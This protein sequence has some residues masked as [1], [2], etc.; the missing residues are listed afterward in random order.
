MSDNDGVPVV[1]KPLYEL[2]IGNTFTAI[3]LHFYQA[4]MDFWKH[5]HQD[6]PE[7]CETVRPIRNR[8]TRTTMCLILGQIAL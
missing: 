5:Q 1:L 7:S 3:F 6:E 8:R 4:V 2:E